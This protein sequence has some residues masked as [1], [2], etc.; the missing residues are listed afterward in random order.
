[1]PV[2]ISTLAAASKSLQLALAVQRA[3]KGRSFNEA[4][5]LK[6][7]NQVADS[8]RALAEERGDTQTAGRWQEEQCA[9]SLY[10]HS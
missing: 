5:Y 4:A 9:I 7:R 1:M 8:N 3:V 6:M 2:T 10:L